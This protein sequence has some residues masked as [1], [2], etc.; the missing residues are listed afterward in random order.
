MVCFK[1]EAMIVAR[2]LTQTEQQ[3]LVTFDQFY[4][5]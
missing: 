5:W 2:K 1:F 3:T 4:F